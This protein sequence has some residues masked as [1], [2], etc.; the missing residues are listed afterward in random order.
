MQIFSSVIL[1]DLNNV[2]NQV[3]QCF[4]DFDLFSVVF[5]FVVLGLQFMRDAHD[6]TLHDFNF[7]IQQSR[8]ANDFI[9]RHPKHFFAQRFLK[10]GIVLTF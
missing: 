4:V 7:I 9:C 8:A 10:K 6:F 5:D 2:G 1:T 3:R